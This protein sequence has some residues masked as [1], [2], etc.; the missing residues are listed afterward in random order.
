MSVQA[1]NWSREQNFDAPSLNLDFVNGKG[2]DSRLKTTRVGSTTVCTEAGYVQTLNSNTAGIHWAPTES[3]V[4]ATSEPATRECLGLQIDPPRTNEYA[5]SNF[6]HLVAG[7]GDSSAGGVTIGFAGKG[8]DG[9]QDSSLRMIE[10]TASG[11]HLINQTWTAQN[12]ETGE[13]TFTASVWVKKGPSTPSTRRFRLRAGGNGGIFASIYWSPQSNTIS[14]SVNSGAV[15]YDSGYELYADNWVRIYMTASLN[16]SNTATSLILQSTDGSDT[17][18]A[19]DT[20]CV[21]FLWGVQYETG[22][23]VA[24]GTGEDE[25]GWQHTG[26]IRNLTPS[27]HNVSRSEQQTYMDLVKYRGLI[28]TEWNAPQDRV[29]N[30]WVFTGYCEIDMRTAQKFDLATVATANKNYGVWKLCNQNAYNGSQGYCF[31]VNYTGDNVNGK[32]SDVNKDFLLKARNLSGSSVP[33][34]TLNV[35]GL[36]SGTEL[37]SECN[38]NPGTFA[39]TSSLNTTA[40]QNMKIASKRNWVNM[41]PVSSQVQTVQGNDS[42]ILAFGGTNLSVI[43][44]DGKLPYVGWIKKFVMWPIWLNNDTTT[45]LQNLSQ[46]F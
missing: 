37:N 32:L 18:Y 2:V 34:P 43:Q 24:I 23:G 46:G 40:L 17:Q 29:G 13:R 4:Y 27:S 11:T 22:G 6:Q 35:R 20:N 41:N 26:H 12:G 42:Q 38:V 33:G 3:G 10:T 31:Q 14:E 44:N 7:S 1:G 30:A 9:L 45:K 21:W 19:G 36:S 5:D 39:F 25:Q 28:N 8:P 15:I 16:D